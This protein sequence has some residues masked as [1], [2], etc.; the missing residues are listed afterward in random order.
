M[1]SLREVLCC[2]KPF[3]TRKSIVGRQITGF[4]VSAW[5]E[6]R[7]WGVGLLKMKIVA[8]VHMLCCCVVW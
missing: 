2:N 1:K 8:S 3:N 6:Q 5:F 7:G 4:E